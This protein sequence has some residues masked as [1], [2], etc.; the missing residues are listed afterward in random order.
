MIF[1]PYLAVS[2][3]AR[4]CVDRSGYP[5][6]GSADELLAAVDVVSGAGSGSLRV[7]AVIGTVV[8]TASDPVALFRGSQRGDASA[9][10]EPMISTS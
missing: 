8:M 7:T 10:P 4:Q 6:S 1:T 2:W 9:E 3:R 5:C